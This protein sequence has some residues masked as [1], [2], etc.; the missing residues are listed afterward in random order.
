MA[1][2]THAVALAKTGQGLTSPW[3]ASYL[4]DPTYAEKCIKIFGAP[5]ERLLLELF[6]PEEYRTSDLIGAACSPIWE[7]QRNVIWP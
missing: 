3:K 7:L 1:K 5:P 4:V 2:T 6:L